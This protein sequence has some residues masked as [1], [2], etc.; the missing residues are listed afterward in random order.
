MVS[1]WDIPGINQRL[2]ELH[3]LGLYFS[4]I[5]EGLNAEY[6][7]SLTRFACIGRAHRLELPDRS[8]IV[9]RKPNKPPILYDPIPIEQLDRTNCHYPL[10]EMLDR[11]PYLY[12]GWPARNG[13]SWCAKHYRKVHTPIRSRSA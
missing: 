11:P 3:A 1:P 9:W 13:F 2:R 4:E 10:G 12:C 7:T 8:N 5:A 6:G